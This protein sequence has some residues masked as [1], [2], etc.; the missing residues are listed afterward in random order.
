MT[1]QKAP[2]FHLSRGPL[3]SRAQAVGPHGWCL[4]VLGYCAYHVT[5]LIEVQTC[6]TGNFTRRF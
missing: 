4:T 1:P 5:N 2:L 6:K 3:E